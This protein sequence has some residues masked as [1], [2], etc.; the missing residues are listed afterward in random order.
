MEADLIDNYETIKILVSTLGFPIFDEIK[1]TNNQESIFIKGKDAYAEGTYNEDGIVVFKGSKCN[2]EETRTAGSWVRNRRQI[3]ID[4]GI[5]EKHDNIYLFTKDHVFNSPNT[6]AMVI[7]G[8][9]ANGWN[10]WKY[11]DGRTLDEVHRNYE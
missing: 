11:K 7:L 2:L 8:R 10:E 6:A 3:L 9:R 5:L 4:D 1:T